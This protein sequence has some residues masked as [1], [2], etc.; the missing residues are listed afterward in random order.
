MSVTV[1]F[2]SVEKNFKAAVDLAANFKPIL[3]EIVGQP[4]SR[5]EWTMR[6]IVGKSFV[7]KTDPIDKSVWA[8][9]ADTT[10]Q[11]KNK[12]FPGKPSLI[13]TGTLFQSL[14]GVSRGT[15]EIIQP[16]KIIYGTSVEYAQ[17]HMTGGKFLPRRRFLGFTKDNVEKWKKFIG[18]YVKEVMMGGK[19]AKI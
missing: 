4:G 7:T 13:R 18:V 6:G 17:F 8:P 16:K 19:G 15:V 11:Y 10:L 5:N 9:L 3:T 14:V 12:K 2:K 1:R